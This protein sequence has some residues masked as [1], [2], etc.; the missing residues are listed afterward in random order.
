MPSESISRG[1]PEEMASL[2]VSD[3]LGIFELA[4]IQ[5]KSAG[6]RG[7]KPWVEGVAAQIMA[8]SGASPTQ[9]PTPTR[10]ADDLWQPRSSRVV[11]HRPTPC[12]S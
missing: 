4:R 12:R 7:D 3:V 2:L 8:L 11:V 6:F 5:L 1:S 9:G 10:D